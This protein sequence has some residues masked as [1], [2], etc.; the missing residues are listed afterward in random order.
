MLQYGKID[1]SEGIN[2]KKTSVSK[3]CMLCHYWYFEDVAFKFEPHVFNIC[4]DVLITVYELKNIVILTVK[5]V[6]YRCIL[7]DISKNKAVNILNNSVFVDK[8]VLQMDFGGN[9]TLVEVIKEGAFW[10]THFRD[11]YSDVNGK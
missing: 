7:W 3:E 10:G 11:I 4:H 1:V 9:K 6:D 2:I 5:G 8:G